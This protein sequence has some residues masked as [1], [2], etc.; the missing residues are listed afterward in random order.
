MKGK[1]IMYLSSKG[2]FYLLFVIQEIPRPSYTNILVHLYIPIRRVLLGLAQCAH[3]ELTNRP[4]VFRWFPHTR[5]TK[6]FGCIQSELSAQTC[7]ALCAQSYIFTCP[8]SWPMKNRQPAVCVSPNG[9]K[10]APDYMISNSYRHLS[11][12]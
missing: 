2:E 10:Q 12:V 11:H 7:C 5:P 1:R 4:T 3:Y 9:N 8:F 6:L